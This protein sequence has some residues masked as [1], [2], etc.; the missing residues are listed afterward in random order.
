MS[1]SWMSTSLP[2]SENVAVICPV[3][4]SSDTVWLIL[5]QQLPLSYQSVLHSYPVLHFTFAISL[6]FLRA[7]KGGQFP[8]TIRFPSR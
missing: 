3:T 1:G 4:V 8:A 6:T 5:R 7:E 2:K